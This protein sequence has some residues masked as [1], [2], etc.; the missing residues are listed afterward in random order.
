MFIIIHMF[1]NFD[2][3]IRVQFINDIDNLSFIKGF[4]N[5]FLN[6]FI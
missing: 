4:N 6:N 2:S 1:K 5:L 3:L